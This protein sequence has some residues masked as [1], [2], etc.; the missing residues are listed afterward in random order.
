MN[1]FKK[2]FVTRTTL[3]GKK[4]AS[5]HSEVGT[6]FCTCCRKHMEDCNCPTVST[7]GGNFPLPKH[8]PSDYFEH[9]YAQQKED[10]P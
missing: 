9:N 2:L 6:A 1:N 10:N 8:Q 3:D 7:G 5:I 4:Y